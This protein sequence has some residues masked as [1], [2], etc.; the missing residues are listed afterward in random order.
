[1]RLK[2]TGLRILRIY[3]IFFNMASLI[4][5]RLIE[6]KILEIS[7]V[8]IK[9]LNFQFSSKF[10]AFRHLGEMS[11]PKAGQRGAFRNSP[12]NALSS[13]DGSNATNS[14]CVWEAP[15]QLIDHCHN[16]EIHFFGHSFFRSQCFTF[17]TSPK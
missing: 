7:S 13:M 1:M 8:F 6:I 2:Y 10:R 12:L 17:R 15:P 4:K 14:S 11:P 16:H 3:L 5:H 9:N